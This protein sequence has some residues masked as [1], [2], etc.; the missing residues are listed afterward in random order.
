MD[1]HAGLNPCF[2]DLAALGLGAAWAMALQHRPRGARLGRARVR[3]S[4]AVGKARLDLVQGGVEL[5]TGGAVQSW[6]DATE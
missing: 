2:H 1:Q 3:I 5:G 4:L 6:A